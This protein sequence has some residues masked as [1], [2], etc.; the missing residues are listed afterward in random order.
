MQLTGPR[1]KPTYRPIKLS[2]PAAWGAARSAWRWRTRLSPD[3]SAG[4]RGRLAQLVTAIPGSAA[5][6]TTGA[7]EI[8]SLILLSSC[9]FHADIDGVRSGVPPFGEGAN[10]QRLASPVVRI[11]AERSSRGELKQRSTR[12]EHHHAAASRRTEHGA[13]GLATQNC[14]KI[15]R[16]R[17]NAAETTLLVVIA[18]AEASSSNAATH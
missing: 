15:L 7:L 10:D 5:L 4:R 1:I 2:R 14:C 13:G 18:R 17:A 9:R 11:C 6:K 12:A 3:G 16:C 8:Q